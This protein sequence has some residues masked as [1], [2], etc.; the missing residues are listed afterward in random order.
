MR[1][2]RLV[3][4]RH[5]LHDTGHSTDDRS[6]GAENYVISLRV[7]TPGT[8][9]FVAASA[10][11]C[12]TFESN[13]TT[14]TE[15]RNCARQA[16]VGVAPSVTVDGQS[17]PVSEVE[18]PLLNIVLPE[19]NIFDDPP[20]TQPA[21]TTGLSVGHG[22]AVLLHPLAPGTHTIVIDGSVP[23]IKTDIIVQADHSDF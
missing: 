10:V 7:L 5:R 4:T 14:E 22:W 1:F 23:L 6:R 9:I 8:K 18:T 21:G 2:D 12:S 13:G 11:E 16:D 17:L 15:L 20:G 19:H 3:A